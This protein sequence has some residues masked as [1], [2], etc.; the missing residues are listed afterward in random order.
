MGILT[1]SRGVNCIT[2][3]RF[4]N[5]HGNQ[6]HVT[7]TN[8]YLGHDKTDCASSSPNAKTDLGIPRK[9]PRSAKEK[10]NLLSLQQNR[11]TSH[12]ALQDL[13]DKIEIGERPDKIGPDS[14]L[15]AGRYFDQ[16]DERPQSVAVKTYAGTSPSQQLMELRRKRLDCLEELLAKLVSNAVVP[17]I[18]TA[19]TIE[20]KP[21]IVMPYY[22]DGNVV[23]HVNKKPRSTA[24]KLKLVLAR[25]IYMLVKDLTPT[26]GSKYYPGARGPS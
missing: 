21:A 14:E 19:R 24:E 7:I 16:D 6:A 2:D 4:N 15:Y 26:T 18:G 10:K 23:Q 20:S 8:N 12:V 25:D 5:V 3:S 17:V 1:D 9:P 11:R 13:S 22:S